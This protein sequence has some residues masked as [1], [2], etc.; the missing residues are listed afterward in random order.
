MKVWNIVPAIMAILILVLMSGSVLAQD[1]FDDD[2]EDPF[3][4]MFDPEASEM[5]VI[6]E[7][8]SLDKAELRISM[9]MDLGSFAGMMRASLDLDEDGTIE[10]EEIGELGSLFDEEDPEEGFL[11]LQIL[12]DNETAQTEV[13]TGWTGLL[14]SVDSTE[15]IGMYATTIYT[16]NID[17]SLERHRITLRPIDDE[18][19]EEEWEEDDINW[20]DD[21]EWVD[22]D[23]DEMPFNMT[24]LIKFPSGWEIDLETVEPEMMKQFVNDDGYIELTPDDIDDIGEPE[25]DIVTFEVVRTDDSP[26]PFWIPVGALI[27]GSISVGLFRRRRH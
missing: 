22:D 23:D 14:G 15:P 17:D 1:E 26:F 13:D 8:E 25:G 18:E 19:E 11:G 24:F 21:D 2:Y 10:E 27:I 5:E 12:V 7:W 9:E 3:G 4:G 6:L 20:T 16:W